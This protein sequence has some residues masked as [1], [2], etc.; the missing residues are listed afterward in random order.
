MPPRLSGL[1]AAV[2]TPMHEDGAL[3]LNAIASMVDFL[4]SDGVAGFYVCGSTGEG[5]LL[6]AQERKAV[7]ETFVKTTRGR[8][9]VIVH[10]GHDSVRQAA[11]LAAHAQQIGADAVAAIPPTYFGVA[12]EQVLVACLAEIAA[13][14][15]EMP[16]YYYHVP[17][18]TGVDF[19]LITFLEL[20]EKR[21]PTLAGVKYT[22]PSVHEFQSLLRFRGGAYTILYGTDEMLSSALSVG[23]YGAI[24]TTYNFAAPLYQRIMA[25]H[26]RG[27]AHAVEAEQYRSVEMIRLLYRYRGLP[28]FK[29]VMRLLGHDCG[30]TRLPL[31]ALTPGEIENMKRELT[32]IGFFTWGHGGKE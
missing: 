26:E 20:A 16:F 22:A 5:P 32:E 8:I 9:P 10:V 31:Q 18:L 21:L 11:E 3:N 29:A 13:A 1:I 30:P 15:P 28:A 24:G 14:A 27:D 4:I 23:A 7:A 17:R 2:F 25:A 12:S 19:D 6:T